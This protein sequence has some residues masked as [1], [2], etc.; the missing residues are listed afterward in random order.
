MGPRRPRG[1]HLHK[2]H[3][4]A[5][6][7]PL[8]AG[9]QTHRF[10]ASL[11]AG[12]G[13]RRDL[14]FAPPSLRRRGALPPGRGLTAAAAPQRPHPGCAAPRSEP[15]RLLQLQTNTRH[16]DAVPPGRPRANQQ[17]QVP[18]SSTRT[19]P[20]SS[21]LPTPYRR[22]HRSTGKEGAG[23]ARGLYMDLAGWERGWPRP[24]SRGVGTVRAGRRNALS[25]PSALPRSEGRGGCCSASRPALS[26]RAGRGCGRER[27][28]LSAPL[29][30]RVRSALEEAAFRVSAGCCRGSHPAGVLHETQ[31]E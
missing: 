2:L 7:A 13:A 6:P 5:C 8:P 19:A 12:R 24:A 29:R 15:H 18:L 14:Q 25:P 10:P 4:P 9:S 27:G 16:R 31:N 30:G 21:A 20:R 1:R 23:G 22:R 26:P 3:L 17:A 11:P 28:S